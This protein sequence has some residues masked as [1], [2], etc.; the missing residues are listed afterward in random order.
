MPKLHKRSVSAL[1]GVFTAAILLT[2]GPSVHG[3]EIVDGFPRDFNF[4]NLIRATDSGEML[5]FCAFCGPAWDDSALV[6]SFNVPGVLSIENDSVFYGSLTCLPTD[7]YS[8]GKGITDPLTVYQVYESPLIDDTVGFLSVYYTEEFDKKYHSQLGDA[9][10]APLSSVSK[11]DKVY[12]AT[13]D[14]PNEIVTDYGY[15]DSI[16][17]SDNMFVVNTNEQW[18]QNNY[19]TWIGAPIINEKGEIIGVLTPIDQGDTNKALVYAL[20]DVIDY[21]EDECGFSIY[22]GETDSSYSGGND[23]DKNNGGNGTEKNNNKDSGGNN[24]EKK[25]DK[26]SGKDNNKQ[27]ESMETNGNNFVLIILIVIG[28]AVAGFFIFRK[29]KNNTAVPPPQN[30]ASPYEGQSIQPPA[31]QPPNYGQQMPENQPQVYDQQMPENQPQNYN[32]QQIQQPIPPAPPENPQNYQIFNSQDSLDINQVPVTTFIQTNLTL[33]CVDGTLN[34]SSYP[35]ADTLCIGRNPALCNI[36]YPQS[37]PG[38]SGM[39]CKITIVNGQ[40]Q[41]TD[42]GSSA[43]TFINGVR[44]LPKVPYQMSVGSSFYIGSPKNTFII[45][46]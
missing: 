19:I 14:N 38:V 28:V 33:K 12:I 42:A 7:V 34:G 41:L 26:D 22:G 43:G 40:V 6:I 25:E 35:I 17:S 20:D 39:H 9:K 2:M 24:T 3:D 5:E 32:Q 13:F 16:L 21:L 23:T 27:E 45:T 30:Y 31:N 10:M 18:V 37:E 29:K 11:G 44:I 46:E 15:V 1:C 36:I 4:S 8:N